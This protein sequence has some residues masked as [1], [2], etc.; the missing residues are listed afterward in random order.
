V[1][2]NNSLVTITGLF[3]YPVKSLQGIS[4]QQA[5][6]RQQGLKYDRQWMITDE[7]GRFITQREI[8]QF[9]FIETKLTDNALVLSMKEQ[10]E[11]AISL[12]RELE[13]SDSEDVI[14]F[15][16]R[17][18]AFDE[19]DEVANWLQAALDGF[20]KKKL[21]LKRFDTS[22][23]RPVEPDVIKERA[24]TYF[25]DAYPLLI[26]NESSLEGLNQQ[27]I[28]NGYGAV[29]MKRFRPNIVVNGIS[30]FLE[31]RITE[32][33]DQDSNPLLGLRKPCQRCKITTINPETSSISNPKEPLASL[34]EVNQLESLSG[35]Y[36]G[37]NAI[38]LKGEEVNLE[39][40]MQLKVKSF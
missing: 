8:P 4:L 34:M 32:L 6:L 16:D 15:R 17:C 5:R 19:G 11:V 23:K 36:F 21:R 13:Q 25:A 31:H 24:D 1:E 18:K 40:G 38:V 3:I 28:K 2:V 20:T 9:A 30:S 33:A 10:G 35:A 12:M 7:K 37:E 22:Q 14:V 29:E 26:C 39:C 27:L